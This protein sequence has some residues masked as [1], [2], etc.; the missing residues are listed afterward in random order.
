MEFVPE[1]F[2]EAEQAIRYLLDLGSYEFNFSVGESMVME[3]ENWIS[4]P[5][6]CNWLL[7]YE[8]ERIIFGDIYARVIGFGVR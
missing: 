6:L 8:G 2:A 3:F 5:E 7:K 4:A 1:F